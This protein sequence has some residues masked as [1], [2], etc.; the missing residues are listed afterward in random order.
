MI[1][2]KASFALIMLLVIV[3]LLVAMFPASRSGS[4]GDSRSELVRV[5][6]RRDR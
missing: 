6:I 5:G 3:G 1:K 4:T 2:R